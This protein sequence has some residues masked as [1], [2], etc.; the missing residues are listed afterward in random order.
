MAPALDP[1]G[2]LDLL[3]AEETVVLPSRRAAQTLRGTFDRGQQA[4]GLRA[5]APPPVLTWEEWTTTLWRG[6]LLAG[7][8]DRVLINRLQE[9]SLWAEIIAAWPRKA[10]LSSTALAELSRL[11]RSALALAADANA[12]DR[13]PSTAENYDARGFAAWYQIFRDRCRAD[14]LLPAAL[15]DQALTKHAAGLIAPSSKNRLNFVGFDRLSPARTRFLRQLEANGF[16][17]ITAPLHAVAQNATLHS[18]VIEGGPAEE[19]RW[20]V[21][22]LRQNYEKTRNPH[23][24]FALVLPNPAIERDRLEPLL[25]EILAPE[26]EPV[27]ADLSSAPWQ[28]GH[29]VPLT[30]LPIIEHALFLLRWTK[31]PLP[32]E[33]IGTLLLSPFLAYSEPHEDRARFDMGGLRRSLS[34]RPEL[35]VRQVLSL[36]RKP[37]GQAAAPTLLLR[38]W[39]A[40]DELIGSLRPRGTGSYAD[41]TELVRKLLRTAGWPGPRTLSPAE[42]RAVEAW[43]ALLDGLATLDLGHRPVG[44]AALLERLEQEAKQVSLPDPPEEAT[45]QILSLSETEGCCF[46]GAILLRAND[47]HLPL[48][49]HPHPLLGYR[50]QREGGLPGTDAAQTYADARSALVNLAGRCGDLLLTTAAADEHGPLRL[51]PLASDLN[52]LPEDSQDL[53]PPAVPWTPLEAEIVADTL[54]LPPLPSPRIVGGA[55]VLELQAACGFRAFA[56]LRLGAAVPEDRGLGLDARATGSL[57]HRAMEL[58]WTEVKTQAALRALGDAEQRSAVARAV[59]EAIAPMRAGVGAEDAWASAYLDI[60]QQRLVRV[61]ALWLQHE[62]ERGNFLVLPPEQK[63]TVP[64]GPLELSIR[65]DRID[66]VDGGYV[67]IDYKTSAN[68]HTNHWLGERPEAPQLPLYALLAEPDEVR[69]LAFARVRPGKDMAWLSMEDEAGIFPA[70]RTRPLR[71]LTEDLDAWRTELERLATD[72]A[73]GHTDVSPK[74]FPGTCQYCAHRLL[75]RLD[76]E[77]FLASERDDTDAELDLDRSG[78]RHGVEHG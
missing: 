13:I 9:E 43:E 8:D 65:P 46:E 68:L 29:G 28:F 64:I 20:A 75:C 40:I 76:A 42:F 15:L 48:A 1:A 72:F 30:D 70:K 35:T 77:A 4:R 71:N 34:L 14:R 16:S 21:R 3:H 66:K 57:L 25:R 22:L 52:F 18:A 37:R 12:L 63:Q 33:Q 39:Q 17:I 10:V 38:E 23:A 45:V 26:L 74:S 6:L 5:W 54:P 59:R 27:S 24:R 62:L 31:H 47:H 53:L 58:F 11:A 60:I 50:L 56:S 51:T 41:W 7:T 32:I 44:L 73:Q 61:I 67:F 36:A 69:G 19:L 78:D 55:S 2:L 49:E